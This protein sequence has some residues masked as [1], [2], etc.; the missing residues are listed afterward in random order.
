V[1]SDAGNF[2]LQVGTFFEQA[3]DVGRI[4][5]ALARAAL[6]GAWHLSSGTYLRARR[7]RFL[8]S[9]EAKYT[10]GIGPWRKSEVPRAVARESLETIAGQDHDSGAGHVFHRAKLL[11]ATHGTSPSRLK[12]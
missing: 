8:D 2:A 5:A 1:V 4:R 3:R 11:H 6:R 7:L 10:A 9:A 12:A